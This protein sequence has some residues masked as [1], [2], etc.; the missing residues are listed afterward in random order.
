MRRACRLFV[1]T[2]A[3]APHHLPSTFLVTA[4]LPSS[5]ACS[6]A[7]RAG[8][9]VDSSCHSSDIRAI[10]SA[11]DTTTPHEPRATSAS[12]TVGSD[13][14]TNHETLA[15]RGSCQTDLHT[16]PQTSTGQPPSYVGELDYV[17]TAAACVCVCCV[18]L[19][20]PVQLSARARLYCPATYIHSHTSPTPPVR[21]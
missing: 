13:V 14:T 15:R 5:P 8:R 20:L 18:L 1:C 9:G 3:A 16:Q 17:G 6:D 12:T 10:T 2:P 19:R 11:G 7:V 21:A 4:R